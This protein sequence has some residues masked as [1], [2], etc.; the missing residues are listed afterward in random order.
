MG[1][2]PH[3]FDRDQWAFAQTRPRCRHCGGHTLLLAS[4]PEVAVGLWCGTCGTLYTDMEVRVPTR[5]MDTSVT[6]A[7]K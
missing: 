7:P 4:S 5:A 6:E 3:P 2:P 1:Y